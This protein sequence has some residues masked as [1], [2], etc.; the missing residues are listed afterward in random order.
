MIEDTTVIIANYLH[1]HFTK[2]CVESVR[3]YYPYIPIIVID[4]C[5]PEIVSFKYPPKFYFR[6][7]PYHMGHGIALDYAMDEVKTKYIITL[8]HDVALIK[9]GA[10]EYLFSFMKDEYTFAVGKYKNNQT[11]MPFVDPHFTLWRTDL[12]KRYKLSFSEVTMENNQNRAYHFATA[13]LLCA[14]ME[15]MYGYTLCGSANGLEYIKG[16]GYATYPK[17]QN[18]YKIKRV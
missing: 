6:K 15:R 12:I 10:F 13:Q 17:D 11:D 2:E 4:D 14:R 16:I 8:D 3:K 5:S 7:L 1:P 9:E 18:D